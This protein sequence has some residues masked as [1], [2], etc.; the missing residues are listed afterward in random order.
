M[1]Q[2]KCRVRTRSTEVHKRKKL[3]IAK[4]ELGN[5]KLDCRLQLNKGKK[6]GNEVT[7]INEVKRATSGKNTATKKHEIVR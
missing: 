1:T 4:G 3:P 7:F 2:R 6:L 5:L